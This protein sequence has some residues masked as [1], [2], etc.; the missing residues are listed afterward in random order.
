WY[1]CDLPAPAETAFVDT[2]FEIP[3]AHT[4]GR[5]HITVR[6]EHVSGQKVD[7]SNEYYYWVYSYRRPSRRRP[8]APEL[9]ARAAADGHGVEL[10]WSVALANARVYVI[11]RRDGDGGRFERIGTVRGSVASYVDRDVE[12]LARY[13][14]RVRARTGGGASRWSRPTGPVS[15]PAER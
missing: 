3:A 1:V 11:E 4:R 8:K 7:S 9:T 15:V 10:E 2:D 14:Y 12:P 5:N 6:V 13:V